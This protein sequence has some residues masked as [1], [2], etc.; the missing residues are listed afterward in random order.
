MDS[1]G[2]TRKVTEPQ[3][4][5]GPAK[6]TPSQPDK[7]SAGAA[8]VS[9][10][11][12]DG[13][14]LDSLAT[15]HQA[16]V[17]TPKA[18]ATFRNY[19]IVREIGNGGMGI[20]FQAV[21]TRLNRPVAIKILSPEKVTDPESKDRLLREAK[22]ASAL[23]HP[24]IVTVYEAGEDRG[25]VYIAMEFVVGK[26]LHE[27][28]GSTKASPVTALR[29]AIQIAD[30]LAA[31]QEAGIV[32]RDLK[33]TN[34]MVT[35]KGVI[36]IVDFGLARLT[37]PASDESSGRLFK[38]AEGSIVGTV[39]YMSPEQAEGRP[40]D[41]RSDIFSFG[42][43][44]Y[45]M[46]TGHRAF[47]RESTIG[48]L[49]AILHKDPLPAR[50]FAPGL[51]PAVE[52]VVAR[53]HRKSPDDRWQHALDLKHALEDL[54]QTFSEEHGEEPK[55]DYRLVNRRLIYVVAA[56]TALVSA[57]AGWMLAA[58][59]LRIPSTAVKPEPV[60]TLLTTGSGFNGFPAI[61][62][63]GK[64]MAFASDRAGKGNLDIWLQQIDGGDAIQITSGD[65]DET[66]PAFS[67]NGTQILFRSERDGGGVYIVPALGGSEPQLVAR[68]GRNPSFS[69]DGQSI[70][71]WAGKEGGEFLP[72][73]AK[74][75]TLPA[76]GGVPRQIRQEFAAALFPLW[77]PGTNKLLFLGRL[78]GG[79]S[80]EK[81][82][83]WWVA[84]VEGG[85]AERVNAIP[86][87][88]KQELRWPVG[89][90]M[91]VPAAFSPGG[92]IVFAASLG[93]AVNLW[94]IPF[95]TR[96]GQVTPPASRLTSTT[97]FDL[98][99][100]ST[101][102]G[103]Q[104]SRMAFSSLSLDVDVWSIP[105]D[106]DAG[107][108]AGSPV[109]LT[110]SLLFDAFP[111]L[112]ADGA[113]MAFASGRTSALRLKIRD[114]ATGREH[115]L[116]ITGSRGLHARISGSG[117]QLIYWDVNKGLFLADTRG[118][119]SERVCPDC[120]PPTDFRDGQK[121]LFEPVDSPDDVMLLD[122]GTRQKSSLVPTQ[123]GMRLYG[124]RLSPD[125]KWVAFHAT[126]DHAENMTIFA[127]PVH[128]GQPVKPSEWVAITEGRA[129]EGEASWSPKGDLLYFLS[130][131]D[132][133]R[134]VW[135]RKF[136]RQTGRPVAEPF[137]VSHF[138][139]AARSLKRLGN[140]GGLIGMSVGPGRVILSLGELSG[141]I[142]LSTVKP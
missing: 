33:P 140:R 115:G 116:P 82:L 11:A 19:R 45:E 51:S 15:I 57:A 76:G 81:T 44:L 74:L 117:D 65:A 99:A 91:F 139:T 73:S 10:A 112:T 63:D 114:F 16:E 25:C 66:D 7:R 26:T 96:T 125:G 38:T 31:A 59:G 83:D 128:S 49:S 135:A 47:H 93:D 52:M 55:R 129:V 41:H 106:A 20:V 32:H 46:L 1:E 58:R 118:G 35:E 104:G 8:A 122:L 3:T 72:G 14:N 97:G 133:F 85:T 121:V 141:N 60:I 127:A 110:E 29:Y 77:I 40:V 24:N 108:A 61:S 48:V 4:G 95:S 53:C 87:L 107:A 64:L 134:C 137:S 88:R 6:G 132:G 103:D 36:K 113:Q 62:R 119:A 120:G 71:Y 84:P 28:I 43:I 109:K 100:S 80:F 50:Q 18:G 5:G 78:D 67:L 34:I 27:H 13:S 30:A 56:I 126:A 94:S 105:V 42:S 17:Y 22:A 75:F 130:D 70:V 142:W 124:G 123:K 79:E 39:V 138:H 98:H 37:T 102:M 86:A 89:Q 131:R 21:D 111:S 23:N 54:L 2:Q 69:P 101:Q 9:T 68:G 136:D 12:S 92:D 90:F